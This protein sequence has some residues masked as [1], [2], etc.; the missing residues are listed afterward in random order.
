MSTLL[1][2]E[3]FPP[4]H[5]GSGRWFWE[6]YRRLP[7]SGFI[8]AAGE[9]PHHEQFDRTHDLRLVRLPLLVPSWG[10]RE[11]GSLTAYWRAIQALRRLVRDKEVEMVH[12]GRCLPEGLMALVLR[13]WCGIPY[14]CFM[15]GEEMN[16]AS[17][18]REL[19]WLAR[20][21][22]RGSEFVIA[23]SRNTE[24]ILRERWGAPRELIRVIHP[25]VDTGRFTPSPRDEGARTALGWGG[26]PVVLTVGRLQRRK[27]HDQ[28]IRALRTIRESI[29]DVLYAVAGDGEERESLHDLAVREGQRGHVQ[30]LGALDDEALIRCYQQCDLFVLPNRQVGQDIEGF[31]MVLLEAQA[32]G[33]PVVA[34]ASGGTAETMRVPET[35]RIVPC[36]GPHELAAVIIALLGDRPLLAR[37]GAAARR[38]VVEHFDWAVLTREAERLFR[39][40]LE[41]V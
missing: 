12:C 23:N 6:I 38:W 3:I 16:Y 22:L 25:G 7:R 39:S 41:T 8:I 9:D 27:G 37:M 4:K 40:E 18:S 31:G 28:M 14:A 36:D 35:G 13:A 33:K 34:G 17:S 19:S 5:G 20:R 21:V 24:R 32:C 29:P 30:F 11:I 2:S 26:R 10:V 15:H 1:I